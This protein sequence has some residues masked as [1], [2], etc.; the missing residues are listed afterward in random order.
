[1]TSKFGQQE[2]YRDTQSGSHILVH[3]WL[4]DFWAKKIAKFQLC[5]YTKTTTWERFGA[6][7]GKLKS[8]AWFQGIGK[9]WALGFWDFQPTFPW[10]SSFCHPP[11]GLPGNASAHFWWFAQHNGTGLNW[12]SNDPCMGRVYDIPS[13]VILDRKNESQRWRQERLDMEN[14]PQKYYIFFEKSDC[15]GPVLNFHTESLSWSSR[16]VF[17]CQETGD[18]ILSKSPSWQYAAS[19]A[20]GTLRGLFQAMSVFFTTWGILKSSKRF[21]HP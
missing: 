14:G 7:L 19:G 18:A 16:S 3:L 8:R 5:H 15:C 12:S 13:F 6:N 20:K 2:W 11:S 17:F 10:F 4:T 1:M 21:L 9:P